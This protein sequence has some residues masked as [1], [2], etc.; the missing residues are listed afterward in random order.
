MSGELL[1]YFYLSMPGEY[2]IPTGFSERRVSNPTYILSLT[3]Q[4]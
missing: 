3:G 1:N 2:V 4:L